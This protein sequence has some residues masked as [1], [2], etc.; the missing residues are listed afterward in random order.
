MNSPPVNGRGS[1]TAS[2]CATCTITC[3]S[4][5]PRPPIQ[6]PHQP[7]V[8]GSAT[9]VCGETAGR[10]KEVASSPWAKRTEVNLGET[11]STPSRRAG[12]CQKTRYPEAETVSLKQI[13]RRH[14][15]PGPSRSLTSPEATG[16]PVHQCGL[17]APSTGFAG[18]PPPQ[19]GE[20]HGEIAPQRI[21]TRLRGT[22]SRPKAKSL[23]WSD[24]RGE[25]H[26]GY[27]RMARTARRVVEGA[28]RTWQGLSPR[29][30]I[31]P[32]K[33][34]EVRRDPA[35]QERGAGW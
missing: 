30:R 32:R 34:G 35:P 18:P 16:C 11:G 19:A 2:S 26:E 3:L 12:Q 13:P 22:S 20:D 24:F 14:P 17:C 33:G 25:G 8:T 9:N 6:S 28:Q 1:P 27:A 4:P 15:P 5:L 29:P 10:G 21:L 7:H 31:L 23:Q